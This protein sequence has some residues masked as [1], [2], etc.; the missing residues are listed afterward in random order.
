MKS[1]LKQ[2]LAAGEAVFGS[3]VFIPSPD[4]IEIMAM[5]GFDYVVVDMEHS[6]KSWETVGNMVRAADIHGLPLLIRV[7]ENHEKTI[8]E[9]LE[10]GAAG[11]VIPF[12]QTAEDVRRA[13]QAV[14]YAPRGMRGT[15][16]LTR[17]ARYGSLRAGFVEHTQQENDRLVI[18]G[19]VE[20]TVG[21]ENIDEII[22][23]D[24]PLDALIV[25]RSDL[26]SSMGKPGKVEEPEVLAATDRILKTAASRKPRP[27][28]VG[29]GLYAPDEAPK[30]IDRGCKFFFYSADTGIMLNASSAAAK[31][32]HAAMQGH[33]SKAAA[34]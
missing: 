7:R 31:A 28:P 22:N 1:N 33:G 2:R 12:I 13:S 17:A 25:G 27:V 30:W 11:V 8:L 18:I 16:T 34:E 14:N 9:A 24:P 21:L 23:C 4:I 6:P 10:I 29:I 20:D 32:F 5:A 15:C 19:Q 3:F 26:A